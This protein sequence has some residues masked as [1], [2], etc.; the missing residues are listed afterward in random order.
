[1][2]T[3]AKFKPFI[4]VTADQLVF[5]YDDALVSLAHRFYPKHMRPMERMGLLLGV[6]LTEKLEKK[7][8]KMYYI[9]S[10]DFKKIVISVL[11]GIP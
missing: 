9:E 4:N 6:S 8:N 10:F 2:L 11:S 5:G 3:A 7:L 1:M